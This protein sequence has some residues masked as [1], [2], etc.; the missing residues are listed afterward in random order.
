MRNSPFQVLVKECMH[1]VQVCIA[2][3]MIPTF[4]LTPLRST[5]LL[6]WNSLLLSWN[7]LT[8]LLSWVVQSHSFLF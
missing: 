2:T 8:L 1:R 7:F 5:L 6:S 3:E 4:L